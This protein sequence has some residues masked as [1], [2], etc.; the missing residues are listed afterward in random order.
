VKKFLGIF[1]KNEKEINVLREANRRVSIVLDALEEKIRPGI[2]TIELEETAL[3]LCDRFGVKPAFKG[4]RGFPYAV[5]CSI[6]DQVVH[7]FPSDRQLEEG[8]IVS[9]DFGVI[10]Q[11]FYG[12]SARTFAVGSI[13]DSSRNLMEVTRRA[14]HVGIEHAT[15][16]NQLYDISRAIQ[17]YVEGQGCSVVKRFVGHGIGRSLHEKPEIPNF[18]PQRYTDIPLK[19]GMVLAIEPMVTAGGDEVEILPDKWTAVTKDRSLAAHFEHTVAIT[20]NGPEILSWSGPE[21]GRA[22]TH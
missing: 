18:L 6:N 19:T 22:R 12:D 11:G 10:H 17:G 9:I 7:G 3:A 2:R 1:L 15:T 4:Y 5:C 8:D 20:S 14:L 13:A 21:H 16:G